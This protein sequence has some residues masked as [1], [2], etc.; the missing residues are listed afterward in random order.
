MNEG[1]DWSEEAQK[2]IR[3]RD[4]KVLEL[5]QNDLL[6]KRL[7]IERR[8]KQAAE[9]HLK[10]ENAFQ[11]GRLD[12]VSPEYLRIMCMD[13]NELKTAGVA[14]H[15][16]KSGKEGVSSVLRSSDR[17]ESESPESGATTMEGLVSKELENDKGSNNILH[18]SRGQE[19]VLNAR[20]NAAL[21]KSMLDPQFECAI[22]TSI[23]KQKRVVKISSDGSESESDGEQSQPKRR[24]V[25]MHPEIFRRQAQ[26][27][28]STGNQ[29]Q[30][31]QFDRSL[32]ESTAPTYGYMQQQQAPNITPQ[33]LSCSPPHLHAQSYQH[34]QIPSRTVKKTR[35]G[36]LPPRQHPDSEQSNRNKTPKALRK[37][38]NVARKHG[39]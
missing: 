33:L 22:D 15:P 32:S 23:S 26:E 8:I 10:N 30:S 14:Y 36:T 16:E 9:E 7:V 37:M 20:R 24:Q 35:T 6:C 18:V 17:D 25:G 4:Q 29:V 3:F 34:Y 12:K 27:Q 39:L 31:F 21:V 38:E 28:Y 2:L 11:V 1:Y 13:Y 19:M 5:A